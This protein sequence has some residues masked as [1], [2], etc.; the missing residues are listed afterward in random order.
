LVRTLAM[1]AHGWDTTL[2]IGNRLT[3]R[4]VD[5]VVARLAPTL[6][7]DVSLVLYGCSVC[8][9]ADEGGWVRTTMRPGG[10]D[11][12]CAKIRDALVDQG[13]T[14][15]TVW[16]H[17]EV[18]HT[19]TNWT[20]RRFTAAAGKGAQGEA[21]AGQLVFGTERQTALSQVEAAINALGHRVVAAER[22]AFDSFVLGRLERHLYRAYG[23]AN[24]AKT[25]GGANL[26]ER[27][28]LYPDEVAEIVRAYWR[29]SY[30]S[31]RRITAFA[32]ELIA[33]MRSMKVIERSTGAAQGAADDVGLD[34]EDFADLDAT[35]PG[36]AYERG[37][38]A[39]DAPSCYQLTTSSPE[40]TI[41]FEFDLSYGASK[42]RPPLKP[43]RSDPAWTDSVYGL[44]GE[45]ITT[46][47]LKRDGFRL[48]GDGNRI[49]IATDSFPLTTAGRDEMIKIIDKVFD[50][51][52]DLRRE[53]DRTAPDTTLRYPTAIGAPRHF[54]PSY[55]EP[56]V[57]CVFPLQLKPGTPY[58]RYGT[59]VAASPQATFA[60]PLGGIDELVTLIRRSEAR[61]VA[62][63][64]WSGPPGER[65]GD[66]SEALYEAQRAV[67][68][69]RDGHVRAG[70]VLSDGT[71]VTA[72]NFSP[73]LQGLL[74]LMV[75]YLRTSEVTYTSRDWEK[76][77]KAYL[78]L[79][80]KNPFR[81][82]FRDLSADERRVFD[83]LYDNPRTE[84]W[85]L[86]KPGATAADANNDLFPARVATKQAEWFSPI[87]SWD[88][89]VEKTVT[90]TPLL[91][92]ES[93]AAKKGEEVGC[94]VLFAPLSRIAPYHEGSRV[95]T[96]EMR[97]LGFNWVFARGTRSKE[98]GA[99]GPGWKQMTKALFDM[100]S[101]L[102]R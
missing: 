27:A 39:E 54:A 82:L 51:T 87:P 92:T 83:E 52:E 9:Q 35:F 69:S 17:T 70:T 10:A 79:N 53:C 58:Y 7:D 48:E 93:G 102:N 21:Y 74:I 14:A 66:R 73:T 49:E 28:P 96:V 57:A 85:K 94:E 16:G 33:R 46:H 31:E 24:R 29:D 97:R 43:N 1:F 63:A 37:P 80:V 5:D 25:H 30:W 55:L 34:D 75:S 72:T 60:L 99:L 4:T 64:A 42:V 40:S 11:S 15:A 2:A 76:F 95:V 41:R 89:F 36:P 62:G 90:N 86:A 32:R 12:L 77:A 45:N 23:E 91:R 20:V 26:A 71:K 38:D 88:D 3:D 59:A 84:L 44:E 81:L 13:K 19:T 68:K 61:G 6:T 65:P 78:P 56:R 18:G 22:T 98:G 67:N 8:A 101:E 50:L 47:R 100:A